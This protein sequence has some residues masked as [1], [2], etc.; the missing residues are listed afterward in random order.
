MNDV[1]QFVSGTP[2]LVMGTCPRNRRENYRKNAVSAGAEPAAAG[3]E[4]EGNNNPATENSRSRP[5]ESNGGSGIASRGDDVEG[6]VK[7]DAES[8][9]NVPIEGRKASGI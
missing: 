8:Q 5:S 6:W 1:F 3:D 9:G 4:R 7:V 2:Q